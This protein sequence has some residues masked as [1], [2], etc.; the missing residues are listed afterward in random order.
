MFFC[1]N[2]CC[3]Q[4]HH[5]FFQISKIRKEISV[6]VLKYQNCM[7]SINAKNLLADNLHQ[8]PIKM[9]FNNFYMTWNLYLITYLCFSSVWFDMS[10]ES[11]CISDSNTGCCNG[12]GVWLNTCCGFTF[13][14]MNTTRLKSDAERACKKKTAL[15]YK[16]KWHFYV[17][18]PCHENLKSRIWHPNYKFILR[19]AQEYLLK[20]WLKNVQ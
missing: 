3:I 5:C 9:S 11:C 16:C 4:I 10:A 6:I 2:V 7:Q 20:I 8:K 12:H 18:I 1:Q 17:N 13:S 19:T 14:Q 15:L